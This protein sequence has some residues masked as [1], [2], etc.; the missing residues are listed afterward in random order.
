MEMGELGIGEGLEGISRAPGSEALSRTPSKDDKN[1]VGQ[2]IKVYKDP[3]T[4]K[5]ISRF[6]LLGEEKV[7]ERRS[8]VGSFRDFVTVCLAPT[9]TV[10]AREND[11]IHLPQCASGLQGI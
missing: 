5:K 6:V 8:D 7:K 9:S 11:E 10:T 1:L 3:N 4:K 2:S